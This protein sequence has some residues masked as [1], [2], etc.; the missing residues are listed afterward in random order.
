VRTCRWLLFPS[1]LACVMTIASAAEAPVGNDYALDTSWLC[2]P[3]RVDACSTPLVLAALQPDGKTLQRESR[4]ASDASVDCFYVYPTVSRQASG[5]ADMT[6]DPEEIATVRAQFALFG[7]QCRLYAPMYRQITLSGLHAAL[8]GRK[9]GIDYS[10]PYDD[11]LAAWRH[12]LAYDNRGRGIVLIGHSQSAK[13]LVRLMAQEIDGQP[14]ARQLIT[15]VVPGTS[16]QVPKGLDVGGTFHQLP[17]CRALAQT[18]CVIAWS[19][20]L[21]D[22]PPLSSARYGRSTRPDWEDACVHP[23][24]DDETQGALNA[25]LPPGSGAQNVDLLEV[26]KGVVSGRCT[27]R[28]GL[29][30]L[31][32]STRTD[33][34]AAA[35]SSTLA[36]LQQRRPSWGLHPLDLN[37]ALGTLVDRIGLQSRQWSTQQALPLPAAGR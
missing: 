13:L 37:L 26:A 16:V 23:A 25:T 28:N 24:A 20:Y 1:L 15:A 7:S 2:R 4:P 6:I 35:V 21:E 29:V 3:G 10:A 17:L 5:N 33:A 34:G 11:V 22:P 32:V 36:D 30:Y 9:G 14:V 18:G 12:Y 31:A 19:S 8:K 27:H